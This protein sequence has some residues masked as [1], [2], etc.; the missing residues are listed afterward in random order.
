M[1]RCFILLWCS[2]MCISPVERAVYSLFVGCLAAQQ[3]VVYRDK[4]LMPSDLCSGV[5]CT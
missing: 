5:I 1:S 4:T 3:Q 2:L